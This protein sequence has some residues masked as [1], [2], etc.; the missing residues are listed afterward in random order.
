MLGAAANA[1]KAIASRISGCMLDNSPVTLAS[2]ETAAAAPLFRRSSFALIC[3]ACALRLE[4]GSEPVEIRDQADQPG[5][6][7]AAFFRGQVESA[8]AQQVDRF[9]EARK[10]DA[11]FGA[12][13]DMR[14][15]QHPRESVGEGLDAL[16]SDMAGRFHPK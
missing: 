7:R 14:N 2:N 6:D 10:V 15:L 12:H 5:P 8:R 9:I 16:P 3:F 11:P 13:Q 1:N 4:R